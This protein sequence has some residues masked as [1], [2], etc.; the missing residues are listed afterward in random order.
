[1][2]KAL[3]STR[4]LWF[5]L[6]IGLLFC[7]FLYLVR[8]ILLPFVAGSILAYFLDPAADA[9]ERR[10]MSRTVATATITLL[11]FFVFA[12]LLG[13]LTPILC[14]QLKELLTALPSY[15]TSLRELATPYVTRLA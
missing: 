10:G 7:A 6:T 5:W 13:F 15:L 3:S 12:G 4:R 14:D 9:L 2:S 11:F 1:M 8:S